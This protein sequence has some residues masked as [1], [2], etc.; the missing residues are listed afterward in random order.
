MKKTK[1]AKGDPDMR[2]EYDF[3][4]AER[5]RY[6]RR[7]GHRVGVLLDPDVAELFRDSATVNDVLRSV[8]QLVQAARRRQSRKTAARR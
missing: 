8:A 4:G 7:F 6:A 1:Q 3:R 5:G 2:A